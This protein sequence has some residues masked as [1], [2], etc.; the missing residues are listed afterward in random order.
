MFLPPGRPFSKQVGIGA[1]NGPNGHA[2]RAKMSESQP[3]ELPFEG[4]Y[5]LLRR[6]GAG[7]S[8]TNAISVWGAAHPLRE[9]PRRG[10]WR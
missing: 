4:G 5:E 7:T 10:S 2:N 8:A 9:P 1:C 3:V 6:L